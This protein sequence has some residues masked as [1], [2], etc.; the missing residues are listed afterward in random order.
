MLILILMFI[1]LRSVMK[2]AH[3]DKPSSN[4]IEVVPFV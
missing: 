2:S 3:Y 1:P 4:S